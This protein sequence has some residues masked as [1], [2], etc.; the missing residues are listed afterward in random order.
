ML[1]LM[2][3]FIDGLWIFKLLSTLGYFSMLDNIIT[4]RL[5]PMT[6]LQD[7]EIVISQISSNPLS[8]NYNLSL[9]W[10]SCPYNYYT[11]PFVHYIILFHFTPQLMISYQTSQFMYNLISYTNI[12]LILLRWRSS[13]TKLLWVIPLLH[14]YTW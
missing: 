11:S 2:P 12:F 10:D 8:T 5:L 6:I 13:D 1:L 9:T 14:T 3:L 4:W 7:K